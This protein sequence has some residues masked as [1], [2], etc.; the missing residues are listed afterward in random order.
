LDTLERNKVLI[1]EDD[2][3]IRRFVA[4]NLDR[5]HFSVSEAA[6]GEAALG[7]LAVSRPD[8]VVL[9]IMLPDM[10]G[11][12]LCRRL[13]DTYPEIV[14][15]LLTAL[16]QDQ[17]KIKGLELGADDYMVKPFNPLELVARIKR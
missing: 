10:D 17:D 2:D 15:I 1:V 7:M 11:F 13:R 4:I 8:V 16:G 3:H 6:L 9:D 12:E 5:N 14:I